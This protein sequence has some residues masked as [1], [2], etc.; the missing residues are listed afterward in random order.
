MLQRRR[1]LEEGSNSKVKSTVPDLPPVAIFGIGRMGSGIARSLARAGLRIH[2]FDIRPEASTVVARETGAKAWSTAAEAASQG[3]ICISMVPDDQAVKD[4]YGG[5][6][7]ILAGIK[8]GSIAVDM[9]T[10]LPAT[11]LSL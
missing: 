10:V 9:S 1:M 11:V 2:L 6:D 5:S 4:L 7:G 8:P 3:R